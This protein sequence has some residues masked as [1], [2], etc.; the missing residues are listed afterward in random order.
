M[1]KKILLISFLV[2]SPAFAFAASGACSGHGG[3]SCSAG[4]DS[5]G[6]VICNDGWRN[7]SVSYSSMV[8]CGAPSSSKPKEIVP[9][10][11]PEPR[12][13]P[14]TV[15][16]PKQE[17][18]KPKEIPVVQPQVSKPEVV[19]PV[20]KKVTPTQVVQPKATT[21]P[22]KTVESKPIQEEV[23][24]VEVPAQVKKRGII[25]RFFSFFF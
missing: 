11:K 20:E 1:I 21:T 23:K 6:S 8:M 14:I 9:V 19:K 3:V 10:V 5:D 24:P 25:S 18:P 15:P 13:E 4:A 2:L 7:S 17:I 16:T 12:P 22:V